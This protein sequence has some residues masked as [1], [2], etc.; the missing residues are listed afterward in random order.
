MNLSYLFKMRFFVLFTYFT[1]LLQKTI[2]C[3]IFLLQST[4]KTPPS[5]ESDVTTLKQCP[6]SVLH[7]YRLHKTTKYGHQLLR[8]CH[9]ERTCLYHSRLTLGLQ[10][11][12]D[13]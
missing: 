10:R 6:H 4:K 13:P 12:V 5:K 9:S 7:H 11:L 8:P 1:V 2:V 3:N